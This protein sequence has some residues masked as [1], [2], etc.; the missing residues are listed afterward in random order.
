MKRAI[1]F[2]MGLFSLFKKKPPFNDPFFG[3]LKY[4]AGKHASFFDGKKWFAPASKEISVLIDADA[5][6]PVQAQYVFFSAVERD[7]AMLLAK[8]VPVI[9]DEFKNWKEDF[10]I[11][12]F[13]NEFSLENIHISKLDEVPLKWEI[14]YT[15]VH[16]L[17]HQ[18]TIDFEG[19]EPMGVMIDG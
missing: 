10:V 12:D 3:E 14:S 13:T 15:S 9:E 6:G 1:I 8:I 11:K 18:F 16:D 5:A 4:T 2:T 17:D 19:M 7:Y